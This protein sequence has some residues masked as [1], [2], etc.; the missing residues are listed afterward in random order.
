[1]R[2]SF[3]IRQSLAS[4]E[5]NCT[6]NCELNSE[7]VFASLPIKKLSKPQRNRVSLQFTDRVFGIANF[8]NWTSSWFLTNG[9]FFKFTYSL[10]GD[11]ILVLILNATD[12]DCDV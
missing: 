1:M 5:K 12:L 11:G 9:L 10:L 3:Q 2:F 8:T 6:V 7:P 4:E